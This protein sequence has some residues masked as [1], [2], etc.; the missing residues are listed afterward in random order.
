MVVTLDPPDLGR[1]EIQVTARGKSVQVEMTSDNDSTK[2]L[3]ESQFEDLRSSLQGQDLTLSKLEVRTDREGLNFNMSQFAQSE[4]QQSQTSEHREFTQQSK[5]NRFSSSR[6]RQVE[7]PV[8][9]RA[10]MSA[11]NASGPGRVDVR[12]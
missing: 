5:E 1:V 12:I 4:K 8:V 6:I 11:G 2:N 9:N 3:L 7:M 10:L